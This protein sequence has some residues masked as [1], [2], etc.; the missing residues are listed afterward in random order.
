MAIRKLATNMGTNVSNIHNS[1]EWADKANLNWQV[2]EREL[3]YIEKDSF[4]KSKAKP[5]EGKK[6]LI[7]SETG[8]VLGVVSDRYQ[9]VQPSTMLDTFQIA[10]DKY[11]FEMDR[12]GT[13]GDGKVIWGRADIHQSFNLNGNDLIDYYMYFVTS[14]DGSAATHT[15]LSTMRCACMN[16]LNLAV[17][18]ANL[19]MNV[20]H[21][22]EFK[23]KEMDTRLS[24]MSAA[25]DDFEQ[26][27]EYLSQTPINTDGDYNRAFIELY[28][29]YPEEKG[30]SRDR[31][32]K[33]NEQI[34]VLM[35]TSAGAELS[36]NR[37]NYWNLLNA[38]TY[39]I[40][41]NNRSRSMEASHKHSIMQQGAKRK[42]KAFDSLVA[43]AG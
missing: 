1:D 38:F 43:L 36:S 8:T 24:L 40:D 5:I 11:G 2:E 14:T 22:S 13:Y 41:H 32:L 37:D 12:L 17:K 19:Y 27:V 42:Q 33:R 15:F 29:D 16:A 6:A 9:V 18:Q 35:R 26:K 23:P 4:W 25:T 31:W 3:A 10:V 7:N 21:S 34:K 20:R 39:D 30:R 28:G